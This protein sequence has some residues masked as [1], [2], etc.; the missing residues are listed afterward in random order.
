[1]YLRGDIIK[2]SEDCS[3]AIRQTF[4]ERQDYEG[5]TWKK[6]SEETKTFYFSEFEKSFYWDDEL[7]TQKQVCKAWN[8]KASGPY[9]DMVKDI[10]DGGDKANVYFP[11]Y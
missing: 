6:V 9:T 1:M 11:S 3:R 8:K 7:F 4:E 5:F 10:K 2:P